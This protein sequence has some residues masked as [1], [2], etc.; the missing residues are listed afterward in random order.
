MPG[1]VIGMIGEE[2]ALKKTY[3]ALSLNQPF[4]YC[5]I[6]TYDGHVNQHKDIGDIAEV[7]SDINDRIGEDASDIALGHGGKVF[8]LPEGLDDKKIIN[9]VKRNNQPEN[10]INP[11]IIG[12][13]NGNILNHQESLRDLK[14]KA[15]SESVVQ[16]LLGNLMTFMYNK[17]Y[18]IT[19]EDIFSAAEKT[20]KKVKGAYSSV[21]LVDTSYDTEDAF[22]FSISDPYGIRSLFLGE[23]NNSF[24]FASDSMTLMNLGYK[25]RVELPAGSVTVVNKRGFKET[26]RFLNEPRR[27]CIRDFIYNMEPD[28]V[29][30]GISVYDFRTKA[31]EIVFR[32]NIQKIDIKGSAP[33]R[34]NTYVQVPLEM[35]ILPESDVPRRDIAIK[36]GESKKLAQAK[37]TFLD[38]LGRVTEGQI[39]GLFD[40]DFVE[41]ETPKLVDL[42]K[43]EK[44]G[45][46]KEVHL[47]VACPPIHEDC[48]LG[49]DTTPFMRALE[50]DGRKK[51][52]D[53]IKK[54][55]GADSVTVL[56]VNDLK[57]LLGDEIC[58]G[59][60]QKPPFG[61]PLKLRGLIS[62]KY[63]RKS[64]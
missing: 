14:F 31:G 30:N 20:M 7:F 28:C 54:K 4:D 36:K 15:R 57:E 39:I 19:Q 50:K 24:C 52:N 55:T 10:I 2:N 53:D 45:K 51:T 35:E 3:E 13:A 43:D 29:I 6:T 12:A 8:N 37:E 26:R 38:I 63:Y 1:T 34:G 42:L 11:V 49:V 46:A 44:I 56:S 59:C 32:K 22:M 16:P 23:K 27:V 5:G 25:D 60:L 9:Y 64:Q 17:R 33:V 58:T 41:N 62:N 47:Y 21:F 40:H 61:Y 18:D 48:L